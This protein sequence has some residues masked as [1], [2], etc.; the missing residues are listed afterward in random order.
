MVTWQGTVPDGPSDARETD[1]E[2]AITRRRDLRDDVHRTLE[3]RE[4]RRERKDL[5]KSYINK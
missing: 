2:T 3:Q 4:H 5:N 1:D